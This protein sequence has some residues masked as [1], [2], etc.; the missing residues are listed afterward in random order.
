MAILG[1]HKTYYI[2]LRFGE[3]RASPI[4]ANPSPSTHCR[5]NSASPRRQSAVLFT[6]PVIKP[7]AYLTMKLKTQKSKPERVAAAGRVK[8]HAIAMFLRVAICRPQPL[9]A[10]VPAT[11]EER[12]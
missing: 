2:E 3:R 10:I 1:Q 4:P 6:F 12:T 5:N 7:E 8:S 9:A 11:P